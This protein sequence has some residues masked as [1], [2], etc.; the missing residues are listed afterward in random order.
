MNLYPRTSK[1]FAHVFAEART[2]GGWAE[3]STAF[4]K[5][6][7][8]SIK[9]TVVASRFADPKCT[10]A[11]IDRNLFKRLEATNYKFKSNWKS[12]IERLHEQL[13]HYVQEM[14]FKKIEDTY[15]FIVTENSKNLL[16]NNIRNNR[17]QLF[18]LFAKQ[19]NER[20]YKKF[21]RKIIEQ[22][23]MAEK[24]KKE[25]ITRLLEKH[26]IDFVVKL[27][28]PIK[29]SWFNNGKTMST[30]WDPEEDLHLIEKCVH[31]NGNIFN[32]QMPKRTLMEM[33]IRLAVLK[34][35]YGKEYQT[36]LKSCKSN[37]EKKLNSKW[38]LN[39]DH[40]S[41]TGQSWIKCEDDFIKECH[42]KNYSAAEM[43]KMNGL[44][45]RSHEAVGTRY[46]RLKHNN[47]NIK[48]YSE[49]KDSEVVS[50]SGDCTSKLNLKWTDLQTDELKRQRYVAKK[51]VNDI[52]I[53]GKNLV[54]I[55]RKLQRIN[56]LTAEE[57][58]KL[59][60]S[61]WTSSSS[62]KLI[63]MFEQHTN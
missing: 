42:V 30:C 51:L 29:D 33:I 6:F 53:E 16:M 14:M 59:D 44:K 54:A 52:I 45:G 36:I 4:R 43:M 17:Y 24:I 21:S 40:S 3:N 56:P 57:F 2:L 13:N 7:K 34:E 19:Y 11:Y 15:S 12:D 62:K 26:D 1:V 63:Q 8:N 46:R 18:I 22:V 41:R 49:Y 20:E 60:H 28:H 37:L 27:F 5:Y 9:S 48:Y 61:T 50:V 47:W 38:D 55:R 39:T 31:D 58:G 10:E 32:L 25:I 35:S 23:E